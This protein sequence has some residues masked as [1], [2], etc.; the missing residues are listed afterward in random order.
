VVEKTERIVAKKNIDASNAC[1]SPSQSA[2]RSARRVGNGHYRILLT[3]GW[4][5][6]SPLK[7]RAGAE[8]KNTSSV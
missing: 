1:S 7:T 3:A 2:D 6:R 4:K 8:V 5:N